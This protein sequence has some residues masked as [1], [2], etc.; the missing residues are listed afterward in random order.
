MLLFCKKDARQSDNFVYVVNCIFY[1]YSYYYKQPLL[2][3]H[4]IYIKIYRQIR[5][6]LIHVSFC[7]F[8]FTLPACRPNFADVARS[9]SNVEQ[10]SITVCLTNSYASLQIANEI[11]IAKYSS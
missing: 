6:V 9:T 8:N 11:T 1:N 4:M 5:H 10:A 7:T 2:F 3:L